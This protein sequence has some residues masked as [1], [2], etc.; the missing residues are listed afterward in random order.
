MEAKCSKVYKKDNDLLI[1]NCCSRTDQKTLWQKQS[2]NAHFPKV[3]ADIVKGTVKYSRS[4]KEIQKYQKV[5]ASLF[6]TFMNCGV[7]M[8]A[9][10][11]EVLKEAN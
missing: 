1:I 5:S 7:S 4:E 9:G 10:I 11:D 8:D 6:S 3:N 2:R